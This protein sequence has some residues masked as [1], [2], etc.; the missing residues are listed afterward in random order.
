M[1]FGIFCLISFSIFAS[2]PFPFFSFLFVLQK[3]LIYTSRHFRP[4]N[5]MLD[6]WKL[7]ILLHVSF[8]FPRRRYS[9]PHFQ[10]ISMASLQEILS[11]TLPVHRRQQ[12]D[13][14]LNAL[15]TEARITLGVS[16]AI[17]RGQTA[18]VRIEEG[19][20]GTQRFE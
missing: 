15:F 1:F 2:L 18:G 5:S 12:Q 13:S 14:P 10:E 20:D 4:L 19:W 3:L 16:R 9:V 7:S 6:H 17:P 11:C 8:P